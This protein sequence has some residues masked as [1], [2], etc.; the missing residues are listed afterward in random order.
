MA[1]GVFAKSQMRGPQTLGLQDQKQSDIPEDVFAGMVRRLSLLQE[2]PSAEDYGPLYAFLASRHNTIMTGQTVVVD[3][4]L[5]KRHHR[6]N[7][8][9]RKL[10]ARRPSGHQ[11]ASWPAASRNAADAPLV[12]VSP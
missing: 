10:P 3:Q 5:L 12:K 1:P 11:L 4:G 7:P 2:L 9:G 8:Y 6:T